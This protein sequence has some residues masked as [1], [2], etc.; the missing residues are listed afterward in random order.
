M[1]V[2][3]LPLAVSLAAL[4]AP[5]G[6][7]PDAPVNPGEAPAPGAVGGVCRQDGSCDEGLRCAGERCVVLAEDDAGQVDGGA[8]D[9]GAADAGAV[10]AGPDGG[11]R[12]DGGIVDSGAVDAG[13][14]DG[15]AVDAGASPTPCTTS[16]DCQG[17]ERCG[18]VV[19]ETAAGLSSI[20]Q[21]PPGAGLPGASCA[22]GDECNT[23]LCVEGFCS[24]RCIDAND[25]GADQVCRPEPITIDGVSSTFNLCVTLPDVMCTS[26]ADCEGD[27]RVCGDLRFDE[28]PFSAWCA[29]PPDSGAALGGSCTGSTSL[30]PQCAELLCLYDRCSRMCIDDTDC[31]APASGY[32]CTDVEFID[33]G[34][35]RMC[36]D[37][38]AR[39][40]DCTDPDHVC[41][42]TGDNTDD[43]LEWICREPTR[44]DAPGEPCL[45]TNNCDHGACIRIRDLQGNIVD[46]YCTQPCE[47]STDCPAVLPV[48]EAANFETPSGGT[49]ALRVCSKP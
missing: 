49:Q 14:G 23:G 44:P 39:D 6:C 19:D 45:T 33:S 20:C 43:E 24:A 25:C 35:V 17:N 8:V 47:V 31:G 2:L 16:A 46:S 41:R 3:A 10:D 4:L 1:R 28:E 15:G 12:A 7:A 42:I 13:G 22:G 40:A 48:C 18:I 34:T 27:G 38:C 9:A 29:L 37:V 36:A 30:N 11:A 26:P 21:P 5:L 32:G